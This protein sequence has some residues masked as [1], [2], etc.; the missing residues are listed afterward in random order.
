MCPPF[1]TQSHTVSKSKR[2]RT[3]RAPRRP[4][5]SSGKRRL[6]Q[7]SDELSSGVG[8]INSM[9]GSHALSAYC[10]CLMV[11]RYSMRVS[12]LDKITRW[13]V[14]LYPRIYH[15]GWV[16]RGFGNAGLAGGP[17]SHL[18]RFSSSSSGSVAHESVAETVVFDLTF[19]F[20]SV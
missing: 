10:V 12:S 3:I 14:E 8:V 6:S 15:T 2:I 5:P 19:C 20:V 16:G 4:K 1:A 18:D 17:A 11:D 13:T 9:F 7:S